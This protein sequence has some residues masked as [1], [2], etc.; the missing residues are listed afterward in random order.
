M[1]VQV[2][3]CTPN[4]IRIRNTL[5]KITAQVGGSKRMHSQDALQERD[6]PANPAYL[7]E[8]DSY[9]EH[10]HIFS[11]LIKKHVRTMIRRMQEAFGAGLMAP[12]SRFQHGQT[13]DYFKSNALDWILERIIKQW[14]QERPSTSWQHFSFR[15]KTSGNIG[16]T[17][18]WLTCYDNGESLTSLSSDRCTVKTREDIGYSH[19]PIHPYLI[20]M[21]EN[22]WS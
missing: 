18:E 6:G 7:A 16:C 1:H 20:R 9:P 19:T 14:N 8:S 11:K 4:A 2:N 12:L 21:K 22:A 17:V 5:T 15:R 13:I 3:W 10:S